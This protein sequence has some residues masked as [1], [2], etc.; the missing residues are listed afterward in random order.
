MP[1]SS[2]GRS[3]AVV[4]EHLDGQRVVDNGGAV[5]RVMFLRLDAPVRIYGIQ[6]FGLGPGLPAVR[7]RRSRALAGNLIVPAQGADLILTPR[8]PHL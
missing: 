4:N 8:S 7:A 3:R 6:E 1:G 5:V 2:Q